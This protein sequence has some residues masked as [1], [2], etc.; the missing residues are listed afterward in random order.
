MNVRQDLEV[1]R[2]RQ[3]YKEMVMNGYTGTF[4]IPNPAELIDF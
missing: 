1:M 4:K 3:N 2:K